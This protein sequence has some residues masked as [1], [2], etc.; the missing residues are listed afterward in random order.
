MKKKSDEKREKIS[1]ERRLVAELYASARRN[2]PQR[3]I[4]VWEYND[5]WQADIVEMR[6]YSC[7]NRGHN[8]VLTVIDVLSKYAWAIPLKSKGGSKTA[9]AIAEIIRESE[10]CPKNLQMNMGKEF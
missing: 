4:I 8:Y 3:R 9:N 6:Q 10:R 7:F 1:S 5:L 2:F